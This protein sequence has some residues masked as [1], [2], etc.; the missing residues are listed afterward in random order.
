MIV[1]WTWFSKQVL[2]GQYLW[3]Q[4]SN[5]VLRG[6]FLQTDDCGSQAFSNQ[7]CLSKKKRSFPLGYSSTFSIIKI[8]ISTCRVLK[9]PSEN[10][11]NSTG[12]NNIFSLICN[13]WDWTVHIHLSVWHKI[14]FFLWQVQ[15]LSPL[16][17]TYMFSTDHQ[18][19]K[20]LNF[21]WESRSRL[22]I[23][24][25]EFS[26]PIWIFYILLLKAREAAHGW[27]NENPAWSQTKFWVS[28]FFWQ[29]ERTFAVVVLWAGACATLHTL[30]SKG[31]CG[32][33]CS[34]GK[35]M[36]G[37]QKII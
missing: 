9:T 14:T 35:P 27:T 29:L 1:K 20:A 28:Q 3:R 15:L 22:N 2:K 32:D 17:S 19:L 21:G 23:C 4:K 16:S 24:Q 18:F 34:Q 11:C 37:C 12:N 25:F 26:T 33:H 30:F 36:G 10:F 13:F 6:S 7:S 5:C 8:P 31:G